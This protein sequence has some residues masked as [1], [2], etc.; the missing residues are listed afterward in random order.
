MSK[1]SSNFASSNKKQTIQ[2][3]TIMKKINLCEVCVIRLERKKVLGKLVEELTFKPCQ[4]LYGKDWERCKKMLNNF[5][6]HLKIKTPD[7]AEEVEKT[8]LEMKDIEKVLQ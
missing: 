5:M 2:K 3:I 4:I 6:P 8:L 7:I 1:K